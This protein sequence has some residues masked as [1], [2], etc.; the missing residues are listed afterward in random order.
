[1]KQVNI[2][3]FKMKIIMILVVLCFT[4]LLGSYVYNGVQASDDNAGND[5]FFE[6]TDTPSG[7]DSS[8]NN[9]NN[10]SQQEEVLEPKAFNNGYSAY[11][12]S[13]RYLASLDN[14]VI[15]G[16]GHMS[17]ELGPISIEESLDIRSYKISQTECANHIAISGKYNYDLQ[18]FF[19]G[20]TVYHRKGKGNNYETAK[21]E[22]YNININRRRMVQVFEVTKDTADASGFKNGAKEYSCSF[23]LLDPSALGSQVDKIISSFMKIDKPTKFKSCTIKIVL[24]KYGQ[25]KSYTYIMSGVV[26][27]MGL[28]ADINLTYTE[29]F[30]YFNKGLDLDLNLFTYIP[31]GTEAQ[32]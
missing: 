28:S 2:Q 18:D 25:P 30:G 8:S 13:E 5:S 21:E 31:Y 27:A 29:Q 32:Q 11:A 22:E 14:Y 4:F 19:V 3:P 17:A 7:D 15:K 10:T 20:D 9:D 16:S 1:M 26:Y 6:E 24:N 12:Y 23:T